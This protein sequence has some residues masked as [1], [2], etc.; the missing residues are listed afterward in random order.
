MRVAYISMD[1]G[2]PIFGQ[3]GCS[4]HVQGI[5]GA[6]VKRGAQV[7]LFS[8]SCDGEPSTL[9]NRVR[10]HRLP[11]VPRE[12]RAA[13]EQRC[14]ALNP[15]LRAALEMENPFDLVYERYSLWSFAALDHART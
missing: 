9:L 8:T 1:A 7:D 15:V 6:L 2:V 12:D 10:I 5:V 14:L 4:V 3:K 11:A 13:R